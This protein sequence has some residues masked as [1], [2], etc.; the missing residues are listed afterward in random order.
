MIYI[1][2]LLD[3][4]AVLMVVILL[5]LGMLACRGVHTKRKGYRRADV[6][7]TLYY[8]VLTVS[9]LLTVAALLAVSACIHVL[10]IYSEFYR[11]STRGQRGI[12]SSLR[13]RCPPNSRRG[14]AML[15][16]LGAHGQFADLDA[17]SLV[18]NDRDRD[19]S[20]LDAIRLLPPFRDNAATAVSMS[21]RDGSRLATGRVAF[22]ANGH[23]ARISSG[24]YPSYAARIDDGNSHAL[25]LGNDDFENYAAV[26]AGGSRSSAITPS[27]G[28][29]V[30]THIGSQAHSKRSMLSA[31]AMDP[32]RAALSPESWQPRLATADRGFRVD[33]SSS[34]PP[35]LSARLKG[36]F[37]GK[38]AEGDPSASAKIAAA[39]AMGHAIRYRGQGLTSAGLPAGTRHEDLST[40]G[41]GVGGTMAGA[42]GDGGAGE[43]EYEQAAGGG[44]GLAGGGHAARPLLVHVAAG[45]NT[46]AGWWG[47]LL[48]MLATQQGLAFGSGGLEDLSCDHDVFQLEVT[49]GHTVR[50][51]LLQLPEPYRSILSVRDPRSV[52]LE[53]YLRSPCAARHEAEE[54]H[55]RAVAAAA[56]TAAANAARRHR[57]SSTETSNGAGTGNSPRDGYSGQDANSG[58]ISSRARESP[59]SLAGGV[60]SSWSNLGAV[61]L[62]T[63]W[64]NPG[65]A[66]NGDVA[67]A[68]NAANADASITKR[69]A[70]GRTR[71]ARAGGLT[72]GVVTDASM[73]PSG[74][75]SQQ[76][77][78]AMAALLGGMT[79]R[80]AVTPAGF[81]GTLAG[82]AASNPSMKPS[83]GG[84]DAADGAAPAGPS[85]PSGGG[86]LGQVTRG[87]ATAVY[88]GMDTIVTWTGLDDVH[89]TVQ[90]PSLFAG[91]GGFANSDGGLEDDVDFSDAD[92]LDGDGDGDGITRGS[93]SRAGFG[94][95]MD[96]TGRATARIRASLRDSGDGVDGGDDEDDDLGSGRGAS[97][98]TRLLGSPFG[99]LVGKREAFRAFSSA[100]GIDDFDNGA[101]EMYKWVPRGRGA[102]VH[103]S[104]DNNP[105]H[106]DS[107]GAA[108]TS[109]HQA[110]SSMP[111]GTSPSLNRYGALLSGGAAV[112]SA[113]ARVLGGRGQLAARDVIMRRVGSVATGSRH[114][115]RRRMVTSLWRDSPSKNASSWCQPHMNREEA[116]NAAMRA[117]SKAGCKGPLSFFC[118]AT[119]IQLSPVTGGPDPNVFILKYED[120]LDVSA[121]ASDGSSSEQ[122]GLEMVARWYGLQG[123]AYELFIEEARRWLQEMLHSLQGTA[124]LRAREAG[125]WKAYFTERNVQE[126]KRLLAYTLVPLGYEQSTDR[127]GLQEGPSGG[128]LAQ[129]PK[130]IKG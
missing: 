127:W 49:G 55:A 7:S 59:T 24:D 44:A 99:S 69:T 38:P 64:G 85:S 87:A 86:L 30:S 129:R 8:R 48:Q 79:Q 5:P 62:S 88:S 122:R 120:L 74:L 126:F 51:A 23:A 60:S 95:G 82:A 37:W 12:P 89:R 32:T 116:I 90:R 52:V 19:G 109:I 25:R 97:A 56:A 17:M 100:F 117:V 36:W 76:Q 57:D 73:Q 124:M 125:G 22:P 28:N 111:T 54:R 80:K 101:E 108:S 128:D 61:I 50:A 98:A 42:G 102:G 91:D 67:A 3:C 14:K 43:E 40:K 130:T 71:V 11:R 68:A 1:N 39:A 63:V 94:R 9:V 72:G 13:L 15:A 81:P 113:M 4:S 47:E 26:T 58:G 66:S 41:V 34:P 123:P 21:S 6:P 77:G 114:G 103:G 96:E 46:G 10:D 65:A 115:S 27:R 35:S 78:E 20:I 107:G 16:A 70:D 84:S 93:V 112:K 105:N 110:T 106:D 29:L 45:R 2:P 92:G 104:G 118:S 83:V 119:A 31:T 121:G 18:T 75:T 33:L 53:E